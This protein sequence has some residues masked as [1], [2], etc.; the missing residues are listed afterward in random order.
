MDKKIITLL[1]SLYVLGP[2]PVRAQKFYPDDPLLDDNDRLE[3]PGK[4]AEL[5]LSQ[6]YDRFGHVAHDFGASPLGSEASNVN[7]LDEV[8]NSS[9]FTNRHGWKRM[10]IEELTRGPNQSDGPNPN[11][12]WKVFKGKSQGLTPGFEIAD[13]KG[14]RYVIKL[15]PVAIPELSSAAEV[16]AT[17]LFHA[18]GYNVPENYIV[19]FDPAN[20]SIEPGTMVEDRFGDKVPLTGFRFRRMIRRV[21]RLPDGAMRVM[22]SKYI[23]GEP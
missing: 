8:P 3:T 19:R 5:E 9:W 22:A 16:I 14:D 6:L 7:T 20:F 17:K 4:P 2:Q 13:D 21:P 10:T 1:A 11:V 12:T 15:D 23:P 18:M